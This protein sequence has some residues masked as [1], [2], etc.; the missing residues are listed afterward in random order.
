MSD[1]TSYVERNALDMEEKYY[2]IVI[3]SSNVVD[4]VHK[5]FCRVDI[6]LYILDVE[7]LYSYC[8]NA[9]NFA[10]CFV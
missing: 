3:V 8:I 9:T 5:L 1:G 2:Y 7:D 4:N 10:Y 6:Y